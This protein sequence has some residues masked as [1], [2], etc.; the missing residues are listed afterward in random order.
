[1]NILAAPCCSTALTHP[2]KRGSGPFHALDHWIVM[3]QDCRPIAL[4]SVGATL[5]RATIARSS[6]ALLVV[7]VQPRPSLG[8]FR[9]DAPRRPDHIIVVVRHRRR[10]CLDARLDA[11][12]GGIF[13]VNPLRGGDP[14]DRRIVVLESGA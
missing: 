3:F 11:L 12:G 2:N 6:A 9:L 10:G 14:P 1:M 13:V 4:G 7:R 5:R 8:L